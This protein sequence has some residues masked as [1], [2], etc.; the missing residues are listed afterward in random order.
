MSTCT[1]LACRDN[2]E[3]AFDDL[4]AQEPQRQ[5]E[6]IAD[7]RWKKRMQPSAIVFY[8]DLVHLERQVLNGVGIPPHL[9]TV[10][11]R[12]RDREDALGGAAH[13]ARF[14]AE[15]RLSLG[16]AAK[17]FSWGA[18]EEI[19]QI[20]V[21]LAAREERDHTAMVMT[22][23]KNR[24][25]VPNKNNRVYLAGSITGRSHGPR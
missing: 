10:E 19:H 17:N 6:V 24:E 5:R 23:I 15:V 22:V 7:A 13:A 18:Q 3:A 25:G 8:L 2:F 16:Q 14:A 11:H 20:G 21:D 9:M 4:L 1:A 12:R